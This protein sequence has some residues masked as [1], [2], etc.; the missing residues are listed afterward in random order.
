MNLLAGL[1]EF[2]QSALTM[3]EPTRPTPD[4][5]RLNPGDDEGYM[6]RA[7]QLARK[8][9]Y[10]CHPNPAVG[11][12]IVRHGKIVGEGWHD[13]V[14]QAHAEINALKQAGKASAGATLYV[15]LEPCS[16]HGQT[17]P[18]VKSIIK[19]RISRVVI[20]TEDPNPLVNRSGISALQRSGI[21]VVVGIGQIQA[22]HINRGFLKRIT[23]GIPWVT[24]KIAAS[25][26]GKTAMA[27]GESQWITSQPARKDAH[28]LRAA[29]SG[30][31]TGIGTVLRDD[32][33]M[34]LRIE[35]V[36]R[37]PVRIILD[38]H[39]SMPTNA[40]IL[41][42][43][44]EVLIVTANSAPS[45]RDAFPHSAVDIINC[46]TTAGRINLHEVM[47]ELG[48][49]EM[50]TIL[51]EAG[52]KLGGSMLGQGLVDEIVVYLAPDLLGSNTRGMFEIPGLERLADKLRLEYKD[53]IRV[54]RDLRL[55]LSVLN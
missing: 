7:L 41:G 21:D 11:C 50:N 16:H 19:S 30:I 27:D 25:L 1:K 20:A 51:L 42:G 38:T 17:P 29:A 40:K 14:G 12:V 48:K 37:Q 18:C 45:A 10:T 13:F 55:T 8:G 34:N 5:H 36:A 54:G 6:A 2:K 39:L 9:I 3:A 43:A 52:A 32:P 15:T 35:G 44:G 4:N 28:R 24:L 22:R 23:T 26:D 33:A 31:L 49:R 53:V 46:R 47:A